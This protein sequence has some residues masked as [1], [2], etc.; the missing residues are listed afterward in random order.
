MKIVMLSFGFDIAVVM[1]TLSDY[2]LTSGDTIV[3]VVPDDDSERKRNSIREVEGFLSA[4]VGRGLSLSLDVVEVDDV[5]VEEC[6]KRIASYMLSHRGAQFHLEAS[7][8]VR[9]ICTAM[10]IAG[11]LM[12]DMV[13]SFATQSEAA[14]KKVFVHLPVCSVELTSPKLELLRALAGGKSM[15]LKR[16]ALVV[17]KDV[18]TVS[19]HLEG[20]ERRGLVKREGEGYGCTYGLTPYGEIVH[21]RH[22][23]G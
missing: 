16:L 21:M 23:G 10:V 15:T 7:G 4:L 5:D 11:V 13:R 22:G 6:V 14:P 17:K 9:S 19:R 2:S 20:L 1:R 8:G 12:G 18:S 3:L